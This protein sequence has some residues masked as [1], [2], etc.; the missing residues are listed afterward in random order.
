VTRHR[1][2]EALK[3]RGIGNFY[4]NRRSPA[5]VDAGVMALRPM[6]ALPAYPSED[7]AN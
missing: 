3:A 2:F 6:S 7:G 1:M 4:T 5:Q